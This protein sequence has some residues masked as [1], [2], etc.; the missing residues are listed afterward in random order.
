MA[1]T[2]QQ[3]R[4]YRGPALF[5]FGFRPFFLLG[6]L[7]AAVSV[8]LWIVSYS[9]GPDAL[10]V[11]AGLAFHVHEMVFGYGSAIVAGFLLTAVPN[12]TGR[13]PVCGPPLMVL[14]SVWVAGRAVMLLQPGP[15]WVPAIFDA[16]FLVLFAAVIWREVIAGRNSRNLKV[17]AAVSLLA[18]A[19]IAFHWMSLAEGGLPQ[20]A[21]RTGLATLV[22]LIL[23]IG[24]RITPSFT[25]NWLARKG[26]PLPVAAGR[27]DDIVLA[28]SYVALA[29][30][31]LFGEIFA[32]SVLLLVAG[33]LNIARLARWRGERT[34][35]EPLVTILHAGYAWAALAILLVGLGG[36]WP[37]YVPRIAGLHAAGAG[38]VG[39]MTL[40]VMTR[41][42]L[43]HTGRALTAG[44][45]TLVIYGL[46]NVAT[47]ARVAAPFLDQPYQM[48]ANFLASAL[49]SGAFLGFVFVYGPR[50][51][52][53]RLGRAA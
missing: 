19:N 31:G 22:F 39:V 14:V 29:A 10:P 17:A 7:W 30:W 47:L 34:L 8:P 35:A 36:L 24:G 18:L 23:L 2:S 32:V 28:V 9:V 21:I 15:V 49:W 50:L 4:A 25:R 44:A 6:A 5:S 41:S 46:V 52:S 26:G 40:A 27:F 43:G 42:S 45:G 12:W 51:V 3:V 48:H 33:L 1:T 53:P 20:A 16:A 38:A 11:N 37:V 13:L